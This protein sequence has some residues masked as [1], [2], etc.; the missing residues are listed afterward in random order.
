[1]DQAWR[2]PGARAGAQD[3]S[4]RCHGHRQGI[5]AARTGRGGISN[6][7]EVVV[8]AEGKEKGPLPLRE[9]RR[10]GAGH[11]QG[12][13]DHAVD[14][15]RVARRDGD[16][17]ARDPRRGRVHLHPRR[18]H[19]AM[20]D[21]GAGARRGERGRRLRHHQGLSPSRR[22][23]LHLRRGNRADELDRRQARQP[24][25]Q[26]A[27][28]RRRW[29]LWPADDDQQRRDAGGGAAHPHARRGLV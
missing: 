18:V 6:G 13:R 12:P 10:V 28:P 25:D 2:L 3:R 16:R 17:R 14:A 7:P 11:L 1:M 29:A 4:C 22:R 24:P 15:A 21:Y 8:H 19:R 20:D 23:G 26:A 9:R 5:G 27:V